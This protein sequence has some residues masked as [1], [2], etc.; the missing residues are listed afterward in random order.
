MVKRRAKYK[1]GDIVK[2]KPGTFIGFVE[3]DDERA[4]D[5]TYGVIT[6]IEEFS[7]GFAPNYDVNF[8]SSD[9]IKFGSCCYDERYI[10]GYANVSS[11][12]DD[13]CTE[14]INFLFECGG[15]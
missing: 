1:I 13:I 4:G 10:V 12:D 8:L 5:N 6:A 15:I 14:E 11:D 3:D 9:S 2:I 7:F